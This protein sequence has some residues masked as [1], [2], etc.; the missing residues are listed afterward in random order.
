VLSRTP[1]PSFSGAPPETFTYT[2]TGKRATMSDASGGTTYSYT[3]RDQV[4][5]KAT[6]QGALS[7]I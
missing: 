3:N 2:L 6:P 5:N 4:L 7:Y 1:D